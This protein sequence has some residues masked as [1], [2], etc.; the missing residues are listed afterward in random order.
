[1]GRYRRSVACIVV[2]A[3]TAQCFSHAWRVRNFFKEIEVDD[4]ITT[5]QVGQQLD[6]HEW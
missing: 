1:M 4:P 6:L 5:S 3:P 2:A